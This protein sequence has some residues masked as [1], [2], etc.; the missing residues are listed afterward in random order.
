M[1]LDIEEIEKR[2]IY[3]QCL[4][5]PNQH[6]FKTYCQN[7]IAKRLINNLKFKVNIWKE[8]SNKE[9]IHEK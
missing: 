4:T 1:K 7:H 2:Y 6:R 3:E 9:N 5:D 8:T